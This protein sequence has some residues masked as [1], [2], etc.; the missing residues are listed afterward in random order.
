MLRHLNISNLAVVNQLQIEFQHGLNILS[1]ETGS[2]KSIIIDAVGLLLG[3]KASPDLIRTGEARAWVEGVFDVESNTPLL[4]ALDLAGISMDAEELIIRREIQ[5]AGRGRVFVNNQ[6]GTVALL[7]ELQPH[8]ID[9]HGQGDQQSLLQAAT[10]MRVYDAWLGAEPLRRET[11]SAWD[12]LRDLLAAYARSRQSEAERLQT[13]DLLNYQVEEIEA[14]TLRSGEDADLESE[15]MRLANAE[16]LA[17][18]CSQ[19]L[20]LLYE[21]ENSLVAQLSAVQKRLGDL[22]AFDNRFATHMESLA[23]AK[24]AIEDATYFVRDYAQEVQ[25]APDRLKF[26]EDR[27]VELDRLK[28]KYAGTLDDIL[29][30]LADLKKRRDDLVNQDQ[31]GREMEQ[32]AVRLLSAWLKQ[33]EK[34]GKKRRQQAPAFE[35]EVLGEMAQVALE[36]SGFRLQF[37]DPASY[38]DGD[39]IEAALRQLNSSARPGRNGLE[40]IEFFFS[41]NKGEQLRQLSATA[42]GGELSRTMLVLKT[43]T[44]PTQFPRTLIFDEVDAGIGGRVAEA[45]GQRLK[46]LSASNQVLCVTHQAQIARYAAA[47]F[48]VSKEVR[49]NRTLTQVAELN[50]QDRVD[51]LARMIAGAE[52][53]TAARKHARELLKTG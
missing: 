47:H 42:S 5:A 1:G 23:G 49:A 44:A 18:L 40:D 26:V 31:R 41:A 20:G 51:E 29:L 46:R 24:Y 38:L 30:K 17:L 34:L 14:A 22:S 19:S 8:L 39:L 36:N 21:E 3:D 9:I 43:I 12:A 53:T 25:V 35:K 6:A 48:R 7:R 37:S 10:H 27:L 11:E 4:A 52:I 13:L 50:Q 28:R 33:A 15:R 32:E 16:K 45:V 2:G